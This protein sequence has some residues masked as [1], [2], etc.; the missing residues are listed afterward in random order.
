MS[1]VVPDIVQKVVKGQNPLHILGD[2]S[3]TRCYTYGGD[4]AKGILASL[5]NS[6]AMNNDFNLS[7][8]TSTT[9][10]DLCKSIWTKLHGPDV[11][12]NFISDPGFE[13]D[14]KNRIPEVTKARDL[15]G[16]EAKTTLS[17]MLDEVIPW[18]KNAI[19]EGHI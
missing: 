8:A 14:V 19:L 12:F 11:P 16:F 13:Y 3:Q 2:G 1:H 7:T 9:V 17:D 10:M 15:L 6:N 18:I 4:L 5:N